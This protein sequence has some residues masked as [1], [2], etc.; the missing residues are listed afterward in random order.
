MIYAQVLIGVL[1]SFPSF[2]IPHKPL[3]TSQL[4]KY[5]VSIDEIESLHSIDVLNRLS[6]ALE[7]KIERVKLLKQW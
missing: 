2:L 7:N 4:D 3:K 6:D 1:I 5:L